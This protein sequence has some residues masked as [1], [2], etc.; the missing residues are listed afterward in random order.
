[1]IGY[2]TISRISYIRECINQNHEIASL[3]S[4]RSRKQDHVYTII[5]I[6]HMSMWMREKD[7]AAW[8]VLE[9]LQCSSSPFQ[10]FD[11]ANV[12]HSL[13]VSNIKSL[14]IY[15]NV[16][17]PTPFTF[18]I[19]FYILGHIWS[20]LECNSSHCKASYGRWSLATIRGTCP[21]F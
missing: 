3:I 7:S 13:K 1:M 10:L 4:S 19:F 16:K 15:S 18:N 2:S 6:L 11:P 8:D 12:P 14:L 21:N 5:L 20:E 9:Q 17:C